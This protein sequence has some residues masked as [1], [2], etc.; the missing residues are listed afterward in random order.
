MSKIKEIGVKGKAEAQSFWDFIR[1]QRVIGFAVGLIIGTAASVTVNSLINNVI[2]PPLGFLM[3]S[4]DGLKGL[5]L[6]L[7][8]TPSGEMAV[9]KYG[10]FLSDLINFLILAL[11]VYLVIK[12][13]KVEMTGNKK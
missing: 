3:G 13:M 11:V 12:W 6:D 2:L 8:V 5:V 9:L 1:G 10:V 4:D 7:G